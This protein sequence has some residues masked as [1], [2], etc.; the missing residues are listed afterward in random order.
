MH[1]FT[2]SLFTTSTIYYYLAVIRCMVRPRAIV[3][4]GTLYAPQ[5]TG[6]GLAGHNLE[7]PCLRRQ[8]MYVQ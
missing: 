6:L 8:L 4:I 1:Y 5:R 7:R 2:L 3:D